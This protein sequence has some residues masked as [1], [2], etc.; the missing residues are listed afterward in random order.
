MQNV[1]KFVLHPV[2]NSKKYILVRQWR[3][4]QKDGTPIEQIGLILEVKSN[5]R[6]ICFDYSLLKNAL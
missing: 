3:V 6:P 5:L 2:Y 1:M 4:S